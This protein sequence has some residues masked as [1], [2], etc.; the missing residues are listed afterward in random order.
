M[1]ERLHR[2]RKSN[3]PRPKKKAMM[4]S[5]AMKWMVMVWPNSTHGMK[6]KRSHA[7]AIPS[8]GQMLGR[9]IYVLV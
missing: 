8:E 3:P 6:R 4:M 1:G 5:L 9:D 2:E 7:S